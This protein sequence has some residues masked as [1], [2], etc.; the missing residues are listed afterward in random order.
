MT[1]SLNPTRHT[2]I[3]LSFLCECL[4]GVTGDV[5]SQLTER[6]AGAA[7]AINGKIYVPG[8]RPPH[9]SNFAVYDPKANAWTRLPDLPTQRNH[10]A[11]VAINGKLYVAGG[12]FGGGF[13]SD[14][15][16][17]LEIYDPATN[18]WSAGAPMPLARGGIN[19]VVANGC[20][21]I[22][23]GEGNK[24]DPSGLFT[25]HDV[26]NP[27][28]NAWKSL[29][30]MPIPVHGVTGSAFLNGLIYLPGGG[31]EQGGNSGSTLHQVYRPDLSCR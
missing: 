27:A 5:A 17:H 16:D 13:Q 1:I 10:L 22:W 21:H 30:P 14:V 25:G 9:G 11:A 8:G 3:E 23:G 19:G 20:F 6:S 2:F 12:R 4:T 7:V 31:T 24:N 26:Y 18:Q 29:G 28:T 15:T